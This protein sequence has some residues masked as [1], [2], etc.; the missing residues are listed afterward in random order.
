MRTI[1]WSFAQRQSFVPVFFRF[2]VAPMSP[3]TI[4]STSERS[5]PQKSYSWLIRSD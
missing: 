1:L 3:A 4:R 2:T 5:L